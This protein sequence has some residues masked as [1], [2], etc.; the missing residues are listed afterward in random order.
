VT[1]APNEGCRLIS[2]TVDDKPVSISDFNDRY[3][4]HDVTANHKIKVVY[5]PLPELKITKKMDKET[6]HKGDTV[7][8]TIEAKNIVKD[9]HAENVIITD[10]GLSKG[11]KIKPDT[12]KSRKGEVAAEENGFTVTID[13]L[14]GEETATVTFDAEIVNKEIEAAEIVNVAIVDSD[15]TDPV[16][17]NAEGVIAYDVDYAWEGAHP[18]K[19]VPGSQKDIPWGTDYTVDETYKA[20]TEVKDVIDGQKGTWHFNGWDKNG[21]ITITDDLTIKGTWTFVPEYDIT[22]SVENG[23]ITDTEK[24]IPEGQ[25]RTIVCP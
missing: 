16:D 20:S 6:Y 7:H 4:F 25:N 13:N 1:Y 22:T 12:I 24:D 19:E 3:G 8:F 14:K 21:T 5:E 11:L 18:D 2:V 15:E 17:D 9:S 10:N 23:E